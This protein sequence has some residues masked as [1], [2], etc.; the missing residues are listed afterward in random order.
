MGAA[1]LISVLTLGSRVLG[2]VRD[3]SC[4]YF[5]GVGAASAAFW[6]AFLIPNLFRRLFGEGALSAAFI[7][8]FSDY[9]HGG[10]RAGARRLAGCVLGLLLLVLIAVMLLSEGT[11]AGLFFFG[12]NSERTRLTLALT[13]LM[14]PFMVLICTTAMLGGR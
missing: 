14:L 5:L 11:V 3:A 1:K 6:T 8:V 13:A 4:T 7:P 10:D 9:H 12:S 2:L